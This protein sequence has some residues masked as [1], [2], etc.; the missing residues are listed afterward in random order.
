[1]RSRETIARLN[2]HQPELDASENQ[3]YGLKNGPRGEL[4]AEERI[5]ELGYG[6]AHKL[7]GP[8]P[9]HELQSHDPDPIDPEGNT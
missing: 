8:T 4:Y 2:H 7:A 5:Q 3:R 9:M 6:I 1:M